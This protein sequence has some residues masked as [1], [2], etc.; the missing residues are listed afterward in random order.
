MTWS[1]PHPSAIGMHQCGCAVGASWHYDD[2]FDSLVEQVLRADPAR[3]RPDRRTGRHRGWIDEFAIRKMKPH[4]HGRQGDNDD[5]FG[6]E[7]VRGNFSWSEESAVHAK[8]RI[9]ELRFVMTRIALQ[10]ICGAHQTPAA[11]QSSG[12]CQ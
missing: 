11:E 8:V 3:R 10:R 6:I 1:T 5:C 9:L 4:A 2:K 12:R 7:E